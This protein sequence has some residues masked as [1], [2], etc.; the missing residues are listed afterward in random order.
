MSEQT[1][2][3]HEVLFSK[4]YIPMLAKQAA[5]RGYPFRDERDLQLG[6]QTL[7]RLRA[8]EE[9]RAGSTN[10]SIHKLAFAL[11]NGTDP[12]AD[13]VDQLQS[14]DQFAKLANE[15]PLDDTVMQAAAELAAAGA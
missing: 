12:A 1:S 4:V 6:L 14:D 5:A 8:D 7:A 13:E 11:L 9:R 15:I 2:K 10:G 3:S